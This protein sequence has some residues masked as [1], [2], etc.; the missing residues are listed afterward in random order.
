M[1]EE[2][3]R[4]IRRLYDAFN[5]DEREAIEIFDPEVEWHTAKEDPDAGVHYGREGVA[6]YLEQWG[7]ALEDIRLEP[8]EFIDGGDRVFVWQR[9]IGRGR[10]SGA[11]VVWEGAYVWTLCDQKI[12][13]AEIFFDREEALEAAGLSE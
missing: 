3:V 9:T 4:V 10:G 6:R 11:E 5:R 12:V 1:S 7:E 13:K 2:N 8:L